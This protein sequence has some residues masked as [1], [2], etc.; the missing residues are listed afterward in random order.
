MI[1]GTVDA[2]LERA[3]LFNLRSQAWFNSE[4]RSPCSSNVIPAGTD[5]G[6]RIEV[7]SLRVDTVKMESHVIRR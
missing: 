7:K 4:T 5:S 2:S 3:G 6:D 1:V